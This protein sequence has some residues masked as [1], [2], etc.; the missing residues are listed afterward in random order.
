[1][2]AAKLPDEVNKASDT[3]LKKGD[4][5]KG[6]VSGAIFVFLNGKIA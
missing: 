3:S 1:M 2:V 6:V 5:P 4:S